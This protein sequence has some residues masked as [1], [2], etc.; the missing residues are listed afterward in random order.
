MA[1]YFTKKDCYWEGGFY[2]AGSIVTT[3]AE[4][5][6]DYFKKYTGGKTPQI[7]VP[8]VPTPPNPGA[9]V[10][11]NANA[12]AREQMEAQANEL[13][14]FFDEKISDQELEEL[15]RDFKAV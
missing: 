15:I 4:T 2:K 3:E 11:N 14:I 8:E 9:P 13:G 7:E 12:S 6:P 5:V 1:K 10:L